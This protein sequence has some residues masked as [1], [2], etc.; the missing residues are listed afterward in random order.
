MYNKVITIGREFGSGGHEIGERLS[1][2]L[3]IPLYDRNL[4]EMASKEMGVDEYSL[5]QVDE[6]ALKGFLATYQIPDT[7]NSVTGYGLPLNDSMF[8][9]QSNIIDKLAQTGP[10][11]IIGRCA[12][13]ILRDNPLCLNIFICA[14]KESRIRRIMDRYDLSEKEA[15][16]SIR[17][18][19]RKRKAYY[20][21]YTDKKWGSIESHQMLLNVSLLGLDQT[22]EVIKHLYLDLPNC[23]SN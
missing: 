9:A 13:Y 15:A 10:C 12:D 8:L 22:V 14:T 21:T 5:E 3:G 11:V 2:T 4:V 20:E 7:P 18:V 6:T 19:D 23:C 1:N 17:R 16:D